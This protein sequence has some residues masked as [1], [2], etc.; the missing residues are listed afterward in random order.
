MLQADRQTKFL[1]P[2]TKTEC[3]TSDDM[4]TIHTNRI[5]AACLCRFAS[6]TTRRICFK[7]TRNTLQPAHSADS[8]HVSCGTM[9]CPRGTAWDGRASAY[10]I[11]D[12]ALS[13]PPQPYARPSCELLVQ[14]GF[15]HRDVCL[16]APALQPSC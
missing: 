12:N 11:Q 9:F 6:T 5:T 14:C 15:S 7:A 16:P 10:S 1:I 3:A 4:H 13:S 2:V 8:E